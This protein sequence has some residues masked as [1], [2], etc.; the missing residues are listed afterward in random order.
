[1]ST[2]AGILSKKKNLFSKEIAVQ[3]R[4]KFSVLKRGENQLSVV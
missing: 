1:M 3:G 4:G 2:G